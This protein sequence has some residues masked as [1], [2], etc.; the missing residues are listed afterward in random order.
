M[1]LAEG[2]ASHR[3]QAQAAAAGP[4][5]YRFRAARSRPGLNS[6]PRPEPPARAREDTGGLPAG[7]GSG[8]AGQLCWRPALAWPAP[9][10]PRAM[11]QPLSRPLV[12]SQSWPWPPAP[13]S[14]RV[15]K[16]SQPWPASQRMPG[17]R[18]QPRPPLQPQCL[19]LAFPSPLP[20]PAF[21][22]LAQ[23]PAQ[24]LSQPCSQCVLKPLA[25]PQPLLPSPAQP[26]LPSHSLPLCKPQYAAQPNPLSR[27]LP[28]SLCVTESF[29]PG[30]PRSHTLPLSQ[31]RLRS[32]LQL[33][34][35]LLLLLL[36]SVL[37]PGAGELQKQERWQ[38]GMWGSN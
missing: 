37:G 29:P 17:S 21:H 8:A 19:P 9:P 36:F 34:P 6:H 24:L 35:A 32:G 28:S 27:R 33:P 13:P 11:A 4:G 12:L 16:R 38:A 22:P 10:P 5:Y 20:R 15:P 2:G 30:P 31:P 18:F 7:V 14:T 23:I 1:E 25:Q 26:C 3:R